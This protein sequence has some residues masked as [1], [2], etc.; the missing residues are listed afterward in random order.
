MIFSLV[1]AKTR[2]KNGLASK[3]EKCISPTLEYGAKTPPFP[4]TGMVGIDSGL[5][6]AKEL[7][8]TTSCNAALF[9]KLNVYRSVYLQREY[10]LEAGRR[11]AIRSFDS[12]VI[13]DLVNLLFD[14]YCG[15]IVVLESRID[16]LIIPLSLYHHGSAPL[17]PP[18]VL[19]HI[20]LMMQIPYLQGVTQEDALNSDVVYLSDMDSKMESSGIRAVCISTQFHTKFLVVHGGNGAQHWADQTEGRRDRLQ[21]DSET[22]GKIFMEFLEQNRSR[23]A[24]VQS[25]NNPNKVDLAT[26][27]KKIEIESPK[28]IIVILFAVS[29]PGKTRSVYHLPSLNFSFYFQAC[30]TASEC[31]GIH[32]SCGIP[33]SKNILSLGNMTQFSLT[34]T[35]SAPCVDHELWTITWFKV[36]LEDRLYIL[37]LFLHSAVEMHISSNI[38]LQ[39]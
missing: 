21:E 9:L 14:L 5:F 16:K 6:E 28:T 29:G 11:Q 38:L 32:E 10:R 26:N 7:E 2:R 19:E 4:Q 23:L 13:E 30:Q 8:S 20:E 3:L 39:L 17:L 1:E 35:N 12:D 27:I 36:I 15:D 22:N 34:I 24:E 37:A 31:Q 25:A 18:Q 33:G